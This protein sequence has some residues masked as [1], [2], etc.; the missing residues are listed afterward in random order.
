MIVTWTKKH[1]GCYVSN[2]GWTIEKSCTG[3]WFVFNPDGGKVDTLPT[4]R[5][6]KQ[7]YG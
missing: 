2:T 1:V 4:L 7:V 3:P 5:R 6:A